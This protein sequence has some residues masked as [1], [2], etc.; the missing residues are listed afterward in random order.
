VSVCRYRP[1]VFSSAGIT[2]ESIAVVF[3]EVEGTSSGRHNENSEDI[4]I[5]LMNR[6]EIGERLRLSDIVFGAR[7]WLIMDAFV[8]MGKDYLL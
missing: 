4:E 3:A 7:A 8:R 1:P 6:Q 2:D 5:F